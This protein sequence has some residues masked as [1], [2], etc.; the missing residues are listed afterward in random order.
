[1]SVKLPGPKT[2]EMLERGI[3]LFRNGLRYSEE[4]EK[5]ARRARR[6]DHGELPGVLGRLIG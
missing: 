5:A 4:C 6:R 1:M 2:L 3:P